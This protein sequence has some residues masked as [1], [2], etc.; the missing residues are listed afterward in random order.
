M[1]NVSLVKFCVLSMLDIF[2]F[3]FLMIK[4]SAGFFDNQIEFKL[5][6]LEKCSFLGGES[7]GGKGRKQRGIFIY[8]NVWVSLF[9]IMIT[10][11]NLMIMSSISQ[12]KAWLHL[13]RRPQSC[14]LEPATL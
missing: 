9:L 5:I 2:Q 13:I 11:N 10:Y 7:Y 12:S 3:H 14:Y 4:L 8:S 6:I 1:V